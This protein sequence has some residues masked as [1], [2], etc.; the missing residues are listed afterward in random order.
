[1]HP[2]V[3]VLNGKRFIAP[4]KAQADSIDVSDAI[5]RGQ[6]FTQRHWKLSIE[7][8]PSFI[9]NLVLKAMQNLATP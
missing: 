5:L 2:D 8:L 9:T 7:L 1:M 4:D 3:V 6:S